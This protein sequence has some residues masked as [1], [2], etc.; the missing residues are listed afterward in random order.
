[1]AE[2]K[3][4]YVPQIAGIDLDFRPRSYIADESPV[5]IILQSIMGENRRQ[6]ARDMLNAMSD[7]ELECMKDEVLHNGFPSYF[8]NYLEGR[9]WSWMG[10]EYLPQLK[11]G[12][13]EIARVVLQS[14]TQDVYSLRARRSSKTGRYY[15]RFVDEYLCSFALSRKS[16]T[17]PLTMRQLIRLIDSADPDNVKPSWS[18]PGPVRMPEHCISFMITK[19]D[20]VEKGLE[21]ISLYSVVY[22]QLYSYYEQRMRRWAYRYVDFLEKE[23]E[24]SSRSQG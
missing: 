21:F 9:D 19:G 6:M 4:L 20:E 3:S 13:F 15:Y 24:S 7:H 14:T 1:M 17:R 10:G 11:P 8:Q 12:E 23:I 22:P 18:W 5:E 2:N 16:S